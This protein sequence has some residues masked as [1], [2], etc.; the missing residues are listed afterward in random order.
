MT[1]DPEDAR[2]FLV[3]ASEGSFGRAANL[4]LVSQPTVSDRMARLERVLGS[5]LFDRG[6]RGITLTGA[7]ERFSSY[8]VRMIDLMDEAVTSV[9]SAEQ[10]PPLRIGLHSTFAHRAVPLVLRSLD[11][12]G[13]NVRVRDAHS[14]QIITMLLDGVLDIG[15][16][17]PGARP[18]GLQFIQLPPDPVIC[19]CAPDHE[20]A[21]SRSVSIS[22][23]ARHR[24]A[25]NLWGTGADDFVASLERAG[26]VGVTRVECTDAMSALRLVRDDGFLA[27]L[28][29]SAAEEDLGRGT[30]RR[31]NLRP[32]LDWV[33][34]LVLAS[35]VGAERDPDVKAVI[36]RARER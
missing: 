26:T 29:Q 15:F 22:T 4:M 17:L 32:T 25:I 14:D 10:Q 13:R 1:I 8:A 21:A 5:V 12:S 2:T 6:P 7:G 34:K 27:V 35:R 24:L 18:P 30:V 28:G 16:V 23:V 3:V 33:I 31:L 9:R 19:V 20:L 11:D 36:R